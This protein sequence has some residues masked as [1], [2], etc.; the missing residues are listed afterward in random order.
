MKKILFFFLAASL[1]IGLSAQSS[2]NKEPFLTKSLANEAVKNVQVETSGG[3]I[4]VTGVNSSEARIEVYVTPNNNS[5]L[6]HQ[7]IQ[8]RLE[9]DYI[10]DISYNNN[11]LTATAKPKNKLN[12]N[13]K[14][15]L[16]ISFKIFVPSTVSTD[17]STSGGSI[18]LANLSGN[19]N[20]R[21]SGGSLNI[22]KL[23]GKIKGR[24][25]GGSIRLSNSQNDIE[26]STSGGSIEANNCQGNL[27]LHTSGGSLRLDDLKGNIN[28]STSGG[29]VRGSSVSGEL[30]A[31]TSGGSINLNKLACSLETSTSGGS[32]NVDIVELGKYV[33]INNSGGN[34]NVQLPKNKGLD[35]NLS[36]RKIKVD[37]LNNFNG[38]TDDNRIDGTMNGGGVPVKIQSGSGSISLGWN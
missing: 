15:A 12:F 6:S 33:K 28:A 23:S 27:E 37:Q 26:L 5:N 25:S 7:E 17:L 22:D 30:K 9:E 19:Q 18:S 20:F 3:S 24:T 21:T 36:A 35:L 4:A 14:R 38:K 29:S 8:K 10:L 32:I 16:N 31:V 11:K 2:S 13:W 34:I 1:S